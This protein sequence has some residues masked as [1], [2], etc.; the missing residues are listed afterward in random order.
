MWL[1]GHIDVLSA[2]RDERSTHPCAML[3]IAD[4]G[5][6]RGTFVLLVYVVCNRL[7][8]AN[9]ACVAFRA[10]QSRTGNGDLAEAIR[11]YCN[12]SYA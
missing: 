7:L 8:R 11:A 2:G 4:R 3:C 5:R 6:L 1:E 10:P 12:L 9:R